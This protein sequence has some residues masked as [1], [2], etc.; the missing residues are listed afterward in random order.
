[1]RPFV[2]RIYSNLKS[3][4]DS[5]EPWDIELSQHTLLVG[6]NTSHKSSII[7]S[8]ELSVA[9]SADDIFGRSAVSDVALLLTLAPAD[10]LGISSTLSNGETASFNARRE[11][12]KTKRPT[13]LGPGADTLVHRDVT[14]ALSGSPASARKAFLSWSGGKITL[15]DVL[16]HLPENLHGKYKDIATHKGREKTVVQTLLEVVTYAG[17]RQREAAKEAKGAEIILESIGDTIEGRPTEEDMTKMKMAV[18]QAREILDVSIRASGSGVGMSGGEKVEALKD[19]REKLSFFTN[20]ISV[21]KQILEELQG[22]LPS[23]G[24]NVDY[25][26]KIVDVAISHSLEACPVCSSQVGSEHLKNCQSFYQQQQKQWEEQSAQKLGQIAKLES[27]IETCERQVIHFTSEI[28]RLE[29]VTV[30]TADSRALP[31][32]DAQSRLEAAMDALGKMEIAN[33]QWENLANARERVFS[34]K[35]EVDTYKELKLACE[36][37]VGRLL[38][39]QA[40]DFSARVQK[41]L[42]N[43]WDF[44]IE[45]L[46]GTKEVFRMG[47]MRD[48]KL[49]A[50]LSGAEWTSVVTAIS[51][52]VSERLPKDAPAILIPEDRAWDGKTLSSVMKG[53]S[54]FDGQVIMASTIRP[55]GRPPKG[56]N[57]IDMDKVSESWCMIDSTDEEEQPVEEK[58]ASK[59]SLN[60]AS[61]GFRVTTRSALILEE[62]GFDTEIIQK[63]SRDTVASIIKD[64]LAPENVSVSDDGT[65]SIV[66]SAKVLP[67][68]PAPNA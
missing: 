3:P 55:T 47:I 18:V 39:E 58:P 22:G 54:N 8:I 35:A 24:E 65:Y 5:G 14:T 56:W 61:G 45:L 38:S 67:M 59:T 12:G 27:D 50:A 63:M 53:F 32:S 49:H 42:P 57:I 28:Q 10:E 37:A 52:A 11:D 33:S 7:Q 6:S 15:D 29:S 1:M 60:H 21:S 62:T 31:V 34:M 17:Q 40:K 2:N 48:G 30:A 26:I 41:Y 23:K 51:M 4:K 46:D 13:H 36:S 20:E 44:N 68:P 64:G 19:A 16:T 25:A 66:R 9:G 43:H